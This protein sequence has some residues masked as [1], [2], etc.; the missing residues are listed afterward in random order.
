MLISILELLAMLAVILVAAELFTNALECL[1]EKL[2]ISEGVTGA[3]FA[4]VGTALP[5]T[6][7]PLLALLAGTRHKAMNEAIGTGAILGAPF[8][9]STLAVFL[10]AISVLKKRRMGGFIKPEA[11][12][13]KR[14]LHFFIAAALLSAAALFVPPGLGW[15][16]IL[17]ALSLVAGYG[18]YVRLTLKA[19][20]G[21]VEAGHNTQAHQPLFLCKLGL[22]E[23]LASCMGQI[24]VGLVL[25]L[26]G[27]K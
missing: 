15:L 4:A 25:L 1:G 11:S 12:G 8:M 2:A 24:G 20:P 3:L 9:L 19:S 21:L 16:K 26:G 27:V 10:M 13:F 17:I 22:P 5:E 18:Y 14:D 7:V 6:M 23:R